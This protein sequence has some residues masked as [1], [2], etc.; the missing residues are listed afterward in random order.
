MAITPEQLRTENL[1]EHYLE[2][3][4]YYLE[5]RGDPDWL[6]AHMGNYLAIKGREII[7]EAEDFAELSQRVRAHHQGALF[8]PHVTKEYP[9]AATLSPQI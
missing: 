5:L 4:R 7:Y 1:P 2:A 6:E 9:E 3:E 8:M